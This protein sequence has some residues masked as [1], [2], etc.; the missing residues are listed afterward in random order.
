MVKV[1]GIVRFLSIVLFLGI[2]TLVYAYIPLDVQIVP[3]DAGM[4]IGRDLFFYGVASFF[5]V[6][7]IV[8][9]AIFRMVGKQLREKSEN[10]FAWLKA[11]SPAIN[12]Y[13]T[14]LVGFIGVINNSLSVS[15]SSYA[16]LNFLGPI[17]LLVWIG[18]FIYLAFKAKNLSTEG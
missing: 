6:V 16:Y 8:F 14:L 12:V 5:L 11:G 13:I 18:G 3:D 15:P 2:L 4:T 17:A 1:V 7:N 10:I 9:V